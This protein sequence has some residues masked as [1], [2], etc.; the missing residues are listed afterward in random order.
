MRVLVVNNFV[1]HGS[2]IDACAGIEQRVLAARGHDVVLLRRDNRDFEAARGL[3][4]AAF[5]AATPYSLSVWLEMERLLRRQRIDVVHLH[6]LVPFVTG[7]VYD[8]CRQHGVPTVQHLH[9]YRAFCLSSYAYR[10]GHRCHD[11]STTAFAACAVYRCYRD[12]YAASAGLVAA[13]WVDWARGRRSGYGAGSY[14]ANSAYTAS[15]HVDHGM[16]A[17]AVRV[18]HNPAEDLGALQGVS[19]RGSAGPAAEPVLTFVGSLI[20][21][22]GPWVA[23]DLAAALPEFRVRFVGAG[24]DEQALRQAVRHRRLTN[25]EFLGPLSGAA[26]A[27]AWADSFL[28]LAPSLWDEPFGIVVPE[29]YSLGVPVMATAAGGLAETVVDGETGIVLDVQ[30]LD[31]AAARVRKLWHDRPRY[32]AMRGAAR[33]AYETR[34][35][36][37]IFAR[38]LEELLLAA[39]GQR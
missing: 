19:P 2:G 7:A 6:N 5:L 29:S 36:E 15:R 21:A 35:G 14:I 38:R 3:K 30:R 8:V 37:E 28:T 4:H 11:C 9:N 34:F 17:D 16:P 18:V 39:A 31:Q 24:S 13:R 1:R 32:Q 22:K 10:G 26:K 25:V 12:S 23:L 27:A 20:A 33:G